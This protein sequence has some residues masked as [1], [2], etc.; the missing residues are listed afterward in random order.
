MATD[1]HPRAGLLSRDTR[2]RWMTKLLGNWAM[3]GFSGLDSDVDQCLLVVPKAG[4]K[5]PPP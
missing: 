5:R 3:I 1:P 4:V 2:W